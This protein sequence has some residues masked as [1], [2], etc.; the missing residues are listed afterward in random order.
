MRAG[1]VEWLKADR[2]WAALA[3][4]GAAVY[5]IV[6]TLRTGSYMDGGFPHPVLIGGLSS[7]VVCT[8][9]LWRQEWSRWVALALTTATVAFVLVQIY[10]D[11]V[12]LLNIATLVCILSMYGY[13]WQL[14][15]TRLQELAKDAEFHRELDRRV[16]ELSR[17]LES[18][19]SSQIV[20]LLRDRVKVDAAELARRAERA[21]GLS[22]SV[23]AKAID[24]VDAS[25]LPVESSGPV[26]SGV[27]PV[28]V[29]YSPPHLIGVYA[30]GE[31]PDLDAIAEGARE[32]S[33][34]SHQ[35]LEFEL[36]PTTDSIE[37]FE[38]G[39]AV[40][41]KLAAEFMDVDC[42]GVY[43]PHDA[44]RLRPSPE[45]REELRRGNLTKK[46]DPSR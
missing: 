31:P 26:V 34:A 24:P 16:E 33:N 6:H 2:S 14:P 25:F 8:G 38:H 40:T 44:R 32:E 21:F 36:L 7:F 43:L 10:Y 27:G 20:L 41:G 9:L 11:G 15:I 45:L 28:W 4:G 17:K 46:S 42:L 22:F 5:A 1:I 35:S 39:Y 12:S 13:L 23:V 3:F 30:H 18:Q 29:C 37:N 19:D